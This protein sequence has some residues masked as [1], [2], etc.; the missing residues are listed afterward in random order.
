MA[1]ERLQARYR[2]A[3]STLECPQFGLAPSST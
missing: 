1:V 2:V 3:G